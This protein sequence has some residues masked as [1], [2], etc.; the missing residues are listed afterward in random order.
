MA[1]V[2]KLLPD[3][4]GIDTNITINDD[5]SLEK[6]ANQY[7]GLGNDINRL[8]NAA[9]EDVHQ[10]QVKLVGNDFGPVNPMMYGAYYQPSINSAE[11]EMRIRGT[12]GL[13]CRYGTW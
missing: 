2:N 7:G 3:V 1:D 6:I 8:G 13:R 9:A 11:S 10:R 12:E 4:G 5:M